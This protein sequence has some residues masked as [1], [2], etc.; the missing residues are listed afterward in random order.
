MKRSIISSIFTIAIGLPGLTDA[1]VSC[2]ETITKV[3]VHEN[4]NVYFTTD[5]T[6]SGSQIWCQIDYSDPDQVSRAYSMLLTANT[7]RKNVWFQWP[8]ISSCTEINATHASPDYI[9][10]RD[11]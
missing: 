9:D 7:A 1:A 2:K 11:Q 4:G 3:I 5:Q 10:V 6:C 8:D